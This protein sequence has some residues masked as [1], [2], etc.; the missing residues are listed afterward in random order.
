MANK[1]I[2]GLYATLSIKDGMTAALKRAEKSLKSFG[3]ASMRYGTIAAGAAG[4]AVIAGTKRTLGQVDALDDLSKSTGIGVADL[5][6]LRKAYSEGGLSADQAG[7]D[8]NKMQKAIVDGADGAEKQAKAFEKLGLNAADLLKLSPAEQFEKIGSAISNVQD[9]AEKV[10]I[11][12]DIFGKSGGG[13]LSVFGNV[14]EARRSLGKMPEVAERFSAAMARSNDLI[15]RLPDKSDQF[16]TGFT[17]GIVGQ[18]LPGLEK[19]NK[20]DFTDLGTGIGESVASAFQSLT[21]GTIVDV[22]A[23]KMTGGLVDAAHKFVSVLESGVYAATE[24]IRTL[25]GKSFGKAF[26]DSI[27][28]DVMAQG[29]TG[30]SKLAQE[31]FNEADILWNNAM[32]RNAQK[33][34]AAASLTSDPFAAAAQSGQAATAVKGPEKEIDSF[35]RRGLM[36]GGAGSGKDGEEKKQTKLLSKIE[37]ALT[38]PYSSKLTEEAVY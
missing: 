3:T 14:D 15:G 18:L 1:S 13:L 10:A 2:G 21:D 34:S 4:A 37:K 9:M 36:I 25:G 8:I 30:R 23:L 26:Q 38:K 24:S 17:A 12:R 6:G 28:A 31:M 32:S 27:N 19:V 5:M 22:F 16:F 20:H 11:A 29:G 7:K 35:L 33:T